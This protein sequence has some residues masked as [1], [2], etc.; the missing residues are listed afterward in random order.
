MCEMSSHTGNRDII[1]RQEII[2]VGE[3]A[4]KRKLL[5]AIGE[6]VNWHSHY[7]KSMEVPP[8]LKIELPY[9]TAISLLSVYLKKKNTKLKRYINIHPQVHSSIAALFG[10]VRVW[11]QPKCLSVDKWIKKM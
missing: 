10:T 8:K 6:N 5:C 11:K 2:N 3:D 9:D 1:K 4:E 7:T